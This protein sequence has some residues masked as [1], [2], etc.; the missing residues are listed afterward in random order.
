MDFTDSE[1]AKTG[2]LRMRGTKKQ[3]TKSLFEMQKKKI[4]IVK[5]WAKL[6][7]PFLLVNYFTSQRNVF[8]SDPLFLSLSWLS[9]RLGLPDFSV[10]S[11]SRRK[12]SFFIHTHTSCTEGV[13]PSLIQI[14]SLTFPFHLTPFL[15]F[16]TMLS[17]SDFSFILRSH[18]FSMSL[19]ILP[20]S[21][22]HFALH[23][24]VLKIQLSSS[25][26]LRYFLF[27]EMS[28]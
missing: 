6:R 26:A 15:C 25:V 11:T 10:V 5:L 13:T 21:N 1:G 17:F 22:Y 4:Y 18:Q 2:T 3:S 12:H 24:L 27:K 16:I 28:L 14:S 20:E 19:N 8:S 9:Y 23:R 7:G